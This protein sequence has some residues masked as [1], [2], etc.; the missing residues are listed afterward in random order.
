MGSFDDLELGLGGAHLLRVEPESF[1]RPRFIKTAAQGLAKW[2]AG[3]LAAS[4]T[5]G[6]WLQNLQNTQKPIVSAALAQTAVMIQ[7]FTAAVNDGKYAA[8]LQRAGGDSGIKAAAAAKVGNYATG[9]AA[10]SPGATKMGAALTKI[11]AYEAANLPT[12]YAM[13]KGTVAAGKARVNAWIDIMAAGAGQ[14]T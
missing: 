13:P 10:G 2:E 3:T 12:I 4:G 8:G 6:S 9:T 5:T 14:F 11:I 7:R 1:D